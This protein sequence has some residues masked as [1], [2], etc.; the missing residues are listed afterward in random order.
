MPFVMSAMVTLALALTF[1]T[2]WA[3]GEFLA[4]RGFPLPDPSSRIGAIDGLRGYLALSVFACHY[5]IWARMNLFDRP[6]EANPTRF[7]AA[8]GSTGVALFFMATGLVFYPRILRGFRQVDWRAVYV[9]RVFRILPLSILAFGVVVLIAFGRT[10]VLPDSSFLRIAAKWISGF[11]EPD[12]AGYP[13]SFTLNAGVLWSLWYEWIFYI[14]ILPLCALVRDALGERVPTIA[15]PLGLL[16]AGM[17]GRLLWPAFLLPTMIPLYLPLFACGMIAFEI[18]RSTRLAE[19]CSGRA[20][21][22]IALAGL[23]CAMLWLDEPYGWAMPLLAL[24]FVSIASGNSFGGALS[25]PGSLVL[26]ECSFSIYLL[27]GIVLNLAWSYMPGH[28]P[29]WVA[30]LAMPVIGAITIAASV[31]SYRYVERPMNAAGKLIARRAVGPM[32]EIRAA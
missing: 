7:F 24:F 10:G 8:L 26:G 12:I 30:V 19:I 23:A 29:M 6:W 20:M 17:A 18:A 2:A 3:L 31:A 5:L 9:G 28:L 4:R 1:V 16:I 14:F 27:H 11:G 15:I 25:S 32:V 22:L 21:G 13:Q